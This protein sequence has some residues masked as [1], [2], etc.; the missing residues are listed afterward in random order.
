M[1]ICF[2]QLCESE[3]N[4]EITCFYTLCLQVE[5]GLGRTTTV[6]L[7]RGTL[8]PSAYLVGELVSLG[9]GHS[10]AFSLPGGGVGKF[11]TG[12]FSSLQPT[13]WGSWYV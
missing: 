6:L 11:R 5:P 3:E 1:L 7:S 2:S 12:A 10:Q 4:K 8:K 9:Q 13:W